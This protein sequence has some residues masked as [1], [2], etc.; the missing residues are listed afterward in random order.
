[1]LNFFCLLCATK[2]MPLRFCC[3][4]F[5]LTLNFLAACL[6]QS[7]ACSLPI[8][9]FHFFLSLCF[10]LSLSLFLYLCFFLLLFVKAKPNCKNLMGVWPHERLFQSLFVPQPQKDQYKGSTLSYP[11]K[12]YCQYSVPYTNSHVYT[13]LSG[14]S[15]FCV[16]IQYNSYGN[17]RKALHKELLYLSFCF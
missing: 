6:Y 16:I 11:V 10:F 14:S 8:F 15:I 9:I 12:G 1:M 13:S 17:D 4:K 7:Q 3:L 5:W 2:F